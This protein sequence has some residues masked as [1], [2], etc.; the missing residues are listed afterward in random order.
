MSTRDVTA[1][2][3]QEPSYLALYHSGEFDRRVAEGLALLR[4]C[5]VC[6]RACHVDRL[7]DQTKLCHTGRWARV[8]ACFAHFG[9]E[10][11]LRG[12]GGSGTIFFNWCNLRCVFCQN[13]E[14]SQR[15]LGEEVDA[16]TLAA[17]MLDLQERGC[18]NINLVTPEHVVPQVLE[19]LPHAIGAGLRLPIVYNSSGYDTL[20]SLRL[21][22]GIVDI[23]MPDFKVW[24]PATAARWLGAKDYP[25]V[26]RAAI[27]EMHRQVGDLRLDADGLAVRGLLVRHLVMPDSLDE[28][29]AIVQ[30]LAERLGSDTYLNVMDQYRPEGRVLRERGRWPAL[31]RGISR[32][33]AAAA[34][35]AAR[36]A[37]LHRLD[38]RSPRPRPR[39]VWSR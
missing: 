23:Y 22:D 5:S 16:R 32:D 26:A 2:S 12:W 35:T 11:C 25:A 36:A 37:G 13:W 18:H 17:L 3:Q 9:E 15:G 21:L 24:D 20:H 30:W 14:T 33:E 19:A 29:S 28:T 1:A 4:S 38:E 8:S 10:D 7:A 27:T 34:V 31:A 39:G 6:P